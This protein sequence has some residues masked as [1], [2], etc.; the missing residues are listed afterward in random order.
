[1]NKYLSLS[2]P[3]VVCENCGKEVPRKSN[4]QKYCEDCKIIVE[5]RKSL[6]RYH[7][8]A[9]DPEFREK[10]RQY[11][12]EWQV[13]VLRGYNQKGTNNN[14]WKGGAQSGYYDKFLKTACERCGSQQNLLIHHRD[15]NRYNNEPVNLET[16]CKK[17]HQIEHECWKNFTKGIVRSTE[18]EES[19]E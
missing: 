11:F 1:M 13:G 8:K 4:R 16:L 14:N 19:V 3:T 10:R 6:E 2:N 12:M 7:K 18:K 17:C 5:R 15:R 9:K